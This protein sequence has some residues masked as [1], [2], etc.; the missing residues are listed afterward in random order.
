M[1]VDELRTALNQYDAAVLKE[2]IVMLYKKIPKSRKEDEGL[3]ELLLH[4]SKEKKPA[5]KKETVVDFDALQ[6]DVEQFLEYADEQYYLAPN[7]YVRKEK[8]SK[9]R[10]EV[11]RFIKELQTVGGEDNEAAA[12]LLADI[13]A[14]LSYACSYWVFSSE[15]PFLPVGYKQ[16]DLLRLVLA[17]IFSGGYNEATIKTA[18]FLTLDSNVDRETLHHELLDILAAQLQT[19]DTKELA[20]AQCIAYQ[21]EYIAYQSAKQLFRYTDGIQYRK[22]RHSNYAVELYSML[23]FSLHEYDEGID[24][25]LKNYSER[26]KE[27]T[28]Y[29]LLCYFLSDDELSSLWIREYERA[30]ADGIEPR[31]SLRKEYAERKTKSQT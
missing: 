23:K 21:K 15:D 9:W 27:V 22:T 16:P 25:F 1:K 11:R 31:D 12:L 5:V 2:I 4:F 26:N 14:M 18:V 28:L 24:Y 8:R 7:R 19:P 17:K 10:F 30:V 20:M 13:Y 3:D 6:F 29:C